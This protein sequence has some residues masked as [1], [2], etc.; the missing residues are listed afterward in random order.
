MTLKHES[1]VALNGRIRSADEGWRVPP[2]RPHTVLP[3]SLCLPRRGRQGTARVRSTPF[4]GLPSA[5]HGCTLLFRMEVGP[6]KTVNF[7]D[8]RSRASA[9]LSEVENGEVVVVLRH[10]RPVAEVAPV[11]DSPR[12]VPRWKRPG[13]RLVMRGRSLSA[14]ILEERERERLL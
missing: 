13:P 4:S 11:S 5:V 7:T 1:S 14:A 6:M 10:G 3:G 2:E 12:K 9:L 8:F